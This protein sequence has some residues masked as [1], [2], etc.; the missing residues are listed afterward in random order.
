M[1][2]GG[3]RSEDNGGFKKGQNHDDDEDAMEIG[4]GF[5]LFELDGGGEEASSFLELSLDSLSLL[6]SLSVS[7]HFGPLSLFFPATVATALP[8]FACVV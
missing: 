6:Q 5:P 8:F 3:V 4:H 2:G 7:L 1:Y